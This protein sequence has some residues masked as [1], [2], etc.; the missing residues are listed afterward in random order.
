MKE[1]RRRLVFIFFYYFFVIFSSC[2]YCLGLSAAAVLLFSAEKRQLRL[3]FGLVLGLVTAATC[4]AMRC[5]CSAFAHVY[6]YSA[7]TAR[8]IRV[9][10][11]EWSARVGA[12]FALG[13]TL[14]Q[15]GLFARAL[16]A[17]STVRFELVAYFFV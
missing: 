1:K 9:H 14:V 2:C 3:L 12:S 15:D 16:F 17:G 11:Y 8:R 13:S 6:V 5:D 4:A 7:L 10:G